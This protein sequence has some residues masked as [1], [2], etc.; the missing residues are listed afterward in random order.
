MPRQSKPDHYIACPNCSEELRVRYPFRGY[1]KIQWSDNFLGTEANGFCE[2]SSCPAC[3]HPF[4]ISDVAKLDRVA[5]PTPRDS[6]FGSA[7]LM[8][9]GWHGVSVPFDENNLPEHGELFIKPASNSQMVAALSHPDLSS[10]R[11]LLL[12]KTLWHNINHPQRGFVTDPADVVQEN[13]RLA[14]LQWLLKQYE[15]QPSDDRDVVIEAEL[16]REQGLFD[17]SIKRMEYAII[18]GSTR[19]LAIRREVIA[20]NSAVCIVS[21]MTDMVIC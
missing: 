7:I 19:A 10:D 16:L 9:T 18:C 14:N 17:A 3:A 5:H 15:N 20:K 21:E 13:F 8:A 6:A 4:W 11:E 1:E 2:F 12:R